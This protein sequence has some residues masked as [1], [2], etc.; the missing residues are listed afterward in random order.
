MT[1]ILEISE[2]KQLSKILQKMLSKSLYYVKDMESVLLSLQFY[3]KEIKFSKSI[4]QV[5]DILYDLFKMNNIYFLSN[6]NII[7]NFICDGVHRN[8]KGTHIL[9]SN[10]VTSI[11]SI[12]NFN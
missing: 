7:R 5:K 3:P 4:R 1:L 12:F 11:N 6:D 2:V 9:A 10:F 8:Q